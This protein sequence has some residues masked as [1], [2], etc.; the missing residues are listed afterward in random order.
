MHNAK[1]TIAI[2]LVL[3]MLLSVLPVSALAV[4]I[5]TKPDNGTTE[6]QPFAPGTGGSK[7]FRIPGI[8]TLDNGTLIA[9]C[10]AR[11]NHSGDG[12]GL[13]TIVSV[14]T[15][16][17]ENWEYTYAN[18]L[19]DNGDTYNNLSTCFIDPGIGTD[20]TTAYLIADLWPAG[21]A[22]NTSRYSPVAGKTGYD[23]NGN[24]ALRDASKD[25]VAIGS[26]G[27]NTMAANAA[28]DYYLDLQSL[29]LCHNDGTVVEGYT[30]DA[31]FNITGNGVNTNL[32]FSDSPYQPYPTDYLY[33]T[34]ST[35]GLNWSEP[36]LLNLKEANEQTLVQ[37]PSRIQGSKPLG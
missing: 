13:D 26:N 20:G 9:A 33:M 21:I 36:E 18:Y 30:V 2:C 15:D 6:G 10:D 27:Y 35:D 16:N 4:S 25:T 22:L 28:Y 34:K 8:V 23:A 1:R 19:G 7:N 5:S 11:W 31:Y 32:F 17:G 24:L 29:E 3:C 12:A 37:V 14:S